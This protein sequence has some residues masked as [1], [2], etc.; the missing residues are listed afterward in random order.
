M[1][2]KILPNKLLDEIRK[3]FLSD[4]YFACK[5]VFEQGF[6]SSW[7]SPRIHGPVCRLIS[8]FR[9]NTRCG[10]ILPRD[11]LK[12]TIVS[13]YYPVWRA[14]ADPNFTCMVTLNTA[15]NVAKKSGAI[16][17][18]LRGNLLLRALFPYRGFLNRPLGR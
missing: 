10:I 6:A 12:S 15:T 9:L 4:F 13:I 14:M 18:I 17:N 8:D 3:L 2:K 7:L 1:N 11:W 16:R 5:A